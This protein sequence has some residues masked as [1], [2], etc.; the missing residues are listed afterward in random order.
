MFV[1]SIILNN[2][3]KF[4][5]HI[6]I[7]IGNP[8]QNN[9]L[10]WTLMISAHT[11]MDKS[12]TACQ[13]LWKIALFWYTKKKVTF[14]TILIRKLKFC[15]WICKPFHLLVICLGNSSSSTEVFINNIENIVVEVLWS[16]YKSG[17]SKCLLYVCY[18]LHT[19]KNVY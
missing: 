6:I 8:L 5:K 1:Y 16:A 7:T 3:R 14:C 17:L 4:Y 10:K 13:V 19:P 9:K 2:L 15:I 18:Q 12:L 11:V